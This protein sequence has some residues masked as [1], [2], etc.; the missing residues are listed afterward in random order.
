MKNIFGNIF[1]VLAICFGL[2]V[3]AP[4]IAQSDNSLQK[5]SILD[6]RLL[7]DLPG[8]WQPMKAEDFEGPFASS[9]F[10]LIGVAATRFSTGI[11]GESQMVKS[12]AVLPLENLSGDLEQDLFAEGLTVELISTL[13]KISNLKVVGRRSAMKYK[14][15]DKTAQEIASELGVD[16][17]MEGS[18]QLVGNEL[19]FATELVHAASGE[20]LWSDTFDGGLEDVLSIQRQIAFG[21]AK[22]INATLTPELREELAAPVNPEAYQEYLKFRVSWMGGRAL[23]HLNRAVELDSTFAQ[24]WSALSWRT[25][26][27]TRFG[28]LPTSSGYIQAREAAQKALTLDGLLGTAHGAQSMV[29]WDQDWDWEASSQF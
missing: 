6:G 4:A 1:A 18:I 20:I 12:L 10:P 3:Q 14:G 21:V 27:S 16:G 9:G 13:G 19:H 23:D 26:W 8:D 11:F 5:W 24:A 7:I 15:T 29:C 28:H 25:S 2:G 22:E 17:L